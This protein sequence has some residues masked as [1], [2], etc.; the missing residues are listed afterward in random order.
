[1]LGV[2]QFDR[3]AGQDALSQNA[4]Q[5]NCEFD[6]T[7]EIAFDH[8]NAAVVLFT[9]VVWRSLARRVRSREKARERGA[10]DEQKRERCAGEQ[11]A[12]QRRLHRESERVDTKRRH[13][14][15]NNLL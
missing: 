7:R 12:L 15:S 6:R 11:F 5:L 14:D 13:W 9:L 4:R 8:I 3:V 2:T 10:R 1:M